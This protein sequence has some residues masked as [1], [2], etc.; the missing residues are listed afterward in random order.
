MLEIFIKLFLF[1]IQRLSVIIPIFFSDL[2]KY[3]QVIRFLQTNHERND[4]RAKA[5]SHVASRKACLAAI[6]ITI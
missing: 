1:K 4:E 3:E 6:S 2:H 5:F